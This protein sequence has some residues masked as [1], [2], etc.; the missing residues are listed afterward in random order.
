MIS[1]GTKG[2][3]S[4]TT[5]YKGRTLKVPIGGGGGKRII[6]LLFIVTQHIFY[7]TSPHP[8]RQQK[9]AGPKDREDRR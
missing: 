5:E 2:N 4:S 6:R 7:L 8:H 9:M 1:G 3:Q